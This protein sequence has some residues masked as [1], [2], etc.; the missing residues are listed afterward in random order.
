MRRKD[1]MARIEELRGMEQARFTT[2]QNAF[3]DYNAVLGAIQ[4]L[5]WVLGQMP[6]EETRTPL[7]VAPEDVPTGD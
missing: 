5:D 3:A 6:E 7:V 1:I 4:S 2:Y